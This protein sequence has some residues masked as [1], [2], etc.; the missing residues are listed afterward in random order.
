MTQEGPM[1]EFIDV[2]TSTGTTAKRGA[3]HY[4]GWFCGVSL[5]FGQI[6]QVQTLKKFLTLF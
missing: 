4:W 1:S 6:N 3:T 5:G 2:L